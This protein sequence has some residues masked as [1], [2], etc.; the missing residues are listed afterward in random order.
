MCRNVRICQ[1]MLMY[2]WN[3]LLVYVESMLIIQLGF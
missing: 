3:L 1:L 2:I